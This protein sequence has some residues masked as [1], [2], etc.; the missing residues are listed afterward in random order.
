[1]H[2]HPSLGNLCSVFLYRFPSEANAFF[3][4]TGKARA[5][6]FT[7]VLSLDYA[8]AVRC[9]FRSSVQHP[10]FSLRVDGWPLKKC[11]QFNCAQTHPL[12]RLALAMDLDLKEAPK[13][14]F[15]GLARLSAGL[16]L[17]GGTLDRQIGAIVDR[18]WGSVRAAATLAYRGAALGS[19]WR[20][21]AA[22]AWK[23]GKGVLLK[24]VLHSDGEADFAV[25]VPVNP[26]LKMRFLAA[27]NRW[28]KPE[29]GAEFR[30]DGD[31]LMGWPHAKDCSE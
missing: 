22:A 31:A 25:K 23:P 2:A 14:E 27:F 15:Q 18:E 30:V 13:I 12:G 10:A 7:Q 11:Y 19:R 17:Y 29:F 20:A 16:S 5:F 21:I 3:R 28:Q 4:W 9:L 1:V 8:S 24:A 6:K 26:G